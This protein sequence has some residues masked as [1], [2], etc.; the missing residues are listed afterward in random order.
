MIRNPIIINKHWYYDPSENT[1]RL[2]RFL[3]YYDFLYSILAK[4]K[5]NGYKKTLLPYYSKGKSAP[6]YRRFLWNGLN[7][8]LYRVCTNWN[9]CRTIKQ[10]IPINYYEE[11]ES[12][13]HTAMDTDTVKSASK[14]LLKYGIKSNA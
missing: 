13:L 3:I 12:V 8:L 5:F 14:E 2:G 9:V 7:I 4:H 6:A 11:K 1:I 10:M